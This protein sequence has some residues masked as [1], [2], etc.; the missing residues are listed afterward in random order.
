[1]SKQGPGRALGS[2]EAAR[3]AECAAVKAVVGVVERCAEF[4]ASKGD[5]A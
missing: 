5:Y 2:K 3:L 1:M 4:I